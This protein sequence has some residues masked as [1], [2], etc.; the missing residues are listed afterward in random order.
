MW[1]YPK[2][3]DDETAEDEYIAPRMVD[4]DRMLGKQ[5][6]EFPPTKNPESREYDADGD[7]NLS[8]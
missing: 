5:G 2:M 8:I 6:E 4:V 1:K 3:E 7:W